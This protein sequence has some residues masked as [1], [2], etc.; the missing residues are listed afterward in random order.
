M[1]KTAAKPKTSRTIKLNFAKINYF[2]ETKK[3]KFNIF[4]RIRA[5]S[6]RSFRT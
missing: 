6:T 4:K 5:K 2:D 1:S 3:V